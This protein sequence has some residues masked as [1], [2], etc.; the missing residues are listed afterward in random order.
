[1]AFPTAIILNSRQNT[2]STSHPVSIPPGLEPGSVLLLVEMSH[3][4][5]DF[6]GHPGGFSR[7]FRAPSSPA[8]GN[9]FIDIWGYLF[10]PAEL[11][12]LGVERGDRTA[13]P[14]GTITLT[15]ASN[16]KS[17]IY[18]IAFAEKFPLSYFGFARSNGGATAIDPP[19][20]A[21]SASAKDVLWFAIGIGIGFQWS[22][23]PASYTD[24]GN[25]F[26]T[27]TGTPSSF[28]TGIASRQLNA[29]SEN[30]GAF[31]GVGPTSDWHA[32]TMGIAIDGP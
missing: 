1:M 25:F 10:K 29:A 26:F 19:N 5:F 3:N 2:M 12:I 11:P 9:V 14:G 8:S 4:N 18:A 27:G 28:G 13:V 31:T 24:E 32:V 17:D 22:G 21:Y 6:G 20:L 7:L 23:A 15:S 30:P 16:R